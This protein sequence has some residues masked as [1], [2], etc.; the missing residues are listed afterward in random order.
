M[1]CLTHDSVSIYGDMH[2]TEKQKPYRH[3]VYL[4]APAKLPG[5]KAMPAL[6]SRS[7]KNPAYKPP[8]TRKKRATPRKKK[9]ASLTNVKTITRRKKKLP[10]L[11][12][13]F[14]WF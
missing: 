4:N 3:P 12:L 9:T 8:T 13:K 6:T 11:R 10:K 2:M 5:V 7:M 1:L 14:L